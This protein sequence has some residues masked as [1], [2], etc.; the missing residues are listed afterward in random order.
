[1]FALLV[2]PGPR[3]ALGN[4]M[5]RIRLRQV[6]VVVLP[7]GDDRPAEA[8]QRQAY[9]TLA[10]AQAETGMRLSA[11]ATLPEGYRLAE[12]ASVSYDQLPTWLRPLYVESRYR[13]QD[14]GPAGYYLLMRQYNA[15]RPDKIRVDAL[16]YRSDE[17]QEVR[18][19]TLADGTPAVLLTFGGA[20][21]AGESPLK[22]LIWEANDM[23]FELWSEFLTEGQLLSLAGSVQ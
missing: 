8:V 3:T 12:V 14:A 1:M 5:A 6:D 15:S 17:V 11:P 20:S 4:W 16:E 23:T 21:A 18:E 22:Q 2:L 10:E 7:Q 13:P 9:G 19:V